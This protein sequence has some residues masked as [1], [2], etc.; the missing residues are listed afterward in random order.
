[1]SKKTVSQVI[2]TTLA[3]SKGDVN[4]LTAHVKAITKLSDGVKKSVFEIAV[5]MNAINTEKLY[6]IGGYSNIAEWAAAELGYAR[7]TTLNY[8][9]IAER[10]LEV[11]TKS[12]GKMVINTI[13]ARRD[14]SGNVTADYKIGQL[15]AAG[16]ATADDFVTMDSE[17]VI[18]PEMSA[19][20]IKKAVKTWYDGEPEEEQED[21]DGDEGGNN[22][23]SEYMEKY[24][25]VL[26][27]LSWLDNHFHDAPDDQAAENVHEAIEAMYNRPE[28]D[29]EYTEVNE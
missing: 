25:E 13:C 20:A 21:G 4:K 11:D 7:S 28:L 27:L 17:G 22:P 18:N 15:N 5:R 12:K 3:H 9:K 16:R 6:E 19:D 14:D 8:V 10:F 1:M 2:E 26:N 24:T 23:E 29:H